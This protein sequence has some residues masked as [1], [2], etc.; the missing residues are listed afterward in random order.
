[1]MRIKIEHAFGILKERFCSLKSLPIKYDKVTGKYDQQRTNDWIRTC[2][3]VNN[4]LMDRNNDPFTV[5]L[6]ERW[7]KKEER[8][9]ARLNEHG[10]EDEDDDE[11]TPYGPSEI[12]EVEGKEKFEQIKRIVLEKQ[13]KSDL[14]LL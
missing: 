8:K 5:K 4:F 6:N 12:V 13:G 7:K 1:M 9:L 10:L 3:I 14:L 11:I 2:V